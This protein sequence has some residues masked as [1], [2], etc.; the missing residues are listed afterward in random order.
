MDIQDCETAAGS[1]VF[2]K[3]ILDAD[4]WNCAN[5]LLLIL[6]HTIASI[7]LDQILSL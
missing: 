7:S 4:V 3:G 5:R 6:L 1:L 2:D